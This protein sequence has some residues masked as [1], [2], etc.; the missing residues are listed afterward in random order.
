MVR[1][2]L[3]IIFIIHLLLSVYA[4]ISKGFMGAFPPFA[5]IWG[6]QIFSDLLISISILWYFLY[7]E[8]KKKERPKWKIIFCGIG[9][10]FAGSIS[11]L[12]YILVEKDIF[13]SLK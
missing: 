5:D 9:I 2:S 3:I 4:T 1:I 10:I 8:A 7:L 13:E 12:I 11:P 6:Y